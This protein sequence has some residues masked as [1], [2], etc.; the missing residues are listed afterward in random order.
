MKKARSLWPEALKDLPM[1][2][3]HKASL[4]KHWKSLHTDFQ[5]E[6]EE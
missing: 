5:L 1:D 4:K 2:E 6:S 3:V